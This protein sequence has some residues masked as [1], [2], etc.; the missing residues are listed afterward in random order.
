MSRTP[1]VGTP[2][3]P[4]SNAVDGLTGTYY[5]GADFR[6][7]DITRIDN[8][9]DFNWGAGA[10]D[11]S[12]LN[13]AF[14]AKWNGQIIPQYSQTYT[15]YTLADDGVK[16]WIGGQLV[17]NDWQD[18]WASMASGKIQLQAGQSYDIQVQYFENG[19]PPASVK[20]AWSSRSEVREV[21][22]SSALRTTAVGSSPAVGATP[23]TTTITSAPQNLTASA[24]GPS[25][26]DLA[27]TGV[28]GAAGYLVQRSS[29]G[30]SNWGTVDVTS[31]GQTTYDDTGLSASTTYFYRIEATNSAGTSTPSNIASA[32]TLAAPVVP[33]A[34]VP[35]PPVPPPPAPVPPP[36]AP[37]PPPPVPPAPPAGDIYVLTNNGYIDEVNTQ[38]AATT[39]IGTLLFGTNAGDHDPVNGKFYYLDQNTSTPRLAVWDPTTN[40]NTI[41][42]TLSLSGPVMR[43]TF[44]SQGV[45]YIT[46]DNGDLYTIDTTTAVATFVGTIAANGS[47][48]PAPAGDMIFSSNGADL[49]LEDNG[50]LYEVNLA[51]LSATYLGTDGSV[52]NLQ[53]GID[54]LGGI[55]GTDSNGGLYTLNLANGAV[56]LVGNTGLGS[57]IGDLANG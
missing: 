23:G 19:D 38:T 42:G 47:Q 22:P 48:L 50:T 49:Y 52:G 2:A 53:V 20:L 18:Q 8:N 4:L 11:A 10:P 24:A 26:I 32:T 14:S 6:V 21:V 25:T 5:F 46:A 1:L 35:P 15:F 16:V 39:Q 55:Y 27:W 30:M 37:V 17:I 57:T 43:A 7:Q 29:N 36:P 41:L 3:A 44:N 28:S 13:R 45:L 9:I 51:T 54:S 34:P 12:L 40:S 56:T 33:P 31:S